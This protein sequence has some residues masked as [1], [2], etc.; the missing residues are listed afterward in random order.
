MMTKLW[1]GVVLALASPLAM[2]QSVDDLYFSEQAKPLGAQEQAAIAIAQQWQSA[3]A[4]AAGPV[5]G[6]GGAVQF[7]FGAHQP[8]IVCAVMQ[9]CDVALQPGEQVTGLHL[10]DK[11]RWSVEP[12]VTGSGASATQHLIIK[13]TDVGLETS[14]VV[15]TDRRTYHLRLRSDRS[16]YMPLVSFVYP[17]DT[18]AQWD[19]LRA[20]AQ[21]AQTQRVEQTMPETG[22]YLGDLSFDYAIDGKAPWKPVRVYNDGRKTVLQ[23]PSAMAQTEA[24]ALL[25][26]RRDGG[27]FSASETVMVNYRV[28]GDRY[29]V[30][31][32]FDKAILVAGVGRKQTRVTITRGRP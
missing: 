30:D 5:P 20:Q 9:V 25:V 10:G 4:S 22:E 28:Q 6:P 16:A 1:W 17:E 21:A 27:L 8:S 32:V 15:P 19:A 2:A 11:V 14:L 31:T 12:A 23:L 7:L 3:S 26:V 24:P 29:V 13:A 18:Q